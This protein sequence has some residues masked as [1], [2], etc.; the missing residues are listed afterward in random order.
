[1]KKRAELPKTCA[2]FLTALLLA[3]GCRTSP[4]VTDAPI[5]EQAEEAQDTHPELRPLEGELAELAEEMTRQAESVRGLLLKEPLEIVEGNAEVVAWLLDREL[6]EL[7]ESGDLAAEQATLTAF[8]FIPS[9]L[10]YEELILDLYEEQVRGLYDHREGMLLVVPPEHSEVGDDDPWLPEEEERLQLSMF[11]LHEIV[12]ALQD[13]HFD[14]SRFLDE[15]MTLDESHA[16]RA[17]VEGDAT[18]AM[19]ELLLQAA[20]GSLADLPTLEPIVEAIKQELEAPE[21]ASL[22]DAPL[23]IKETLLFSY[24]QG[25]VFVHALHSVGGWEAVNAAFDSPPSTTQQLMQPERYFDGVVGDRLMMPPVA[26]LKAA[27]YEIKDEGAMG[28]LGLRLF[29]AE[30]IGKEP[31][32]GPSCA[33]AGDAYSVFTKDEE[34]PIAVWILALEDTASTSALLELLEGAGFGPA[35]F[36]VGRLEEDMLAVVTNSSDAVATSVLESLS[37]A[38][39]EPVERAPFRLAPQEQALE[40]D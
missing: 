16:T 7:R 15:E 25:L 29:L 8:G 23:Y 10:D 21:H 32:P 4:T 3:M 27:G 28:E 2:L 31:G 12:H 19:Y 33:W 40:K 5:A 14:L 34:A 35:S 9:D 24:L 13:Q 22:R 39:R 18:Y 38:T 26:E 1:M 6:E 30:H 11:L 20:G 17:L 37:E 36:T